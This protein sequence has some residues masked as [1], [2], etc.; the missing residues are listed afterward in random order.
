MYCL[1]SCT[2]NNSRDCRTILPKVGLF[3]LFWSFLGIPTEYYGNTGCGVF[4][5][6]VQNWTDFCLRINIP[7]GNYSIWRNGVMGRRLKVTKIDSQSQFSISKIIGIFLNFFSLKNINLG[8]HYL[9][10][11]FFDNINF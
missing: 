3:D 7:K 4:K 1:F 10:L 2:A 5:Q 9:L 11:T 8:T 6:G